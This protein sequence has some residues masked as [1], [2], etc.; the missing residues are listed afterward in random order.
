MNKDN[1]DLS[2]FIKG[3]ENS[4][5]LAL[6]EIKE[7]RKRSHWMW[8]IFP[9]I[10]GLGFS[11]ISQ[12]YAISSLDEAKAYLN[13]MTLGSHMHE[14]CKALLELDT[15]DAESIFGFPD[16]LKLKSSMTLFDMAAPDNE[17]FSKVLDKFFNGQRDEKTIDHICG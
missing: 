9:Q 12:Y 1:I 3:H 15:D 17:M 16:Y 14:L 2:R 7:G 10:E 13:D 5:R 8:Y 6:L 4:Y 11:D